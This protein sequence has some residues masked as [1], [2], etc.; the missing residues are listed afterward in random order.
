[1]YT[2]VG[3]TEEAVI[4]WLVPL[5]QVNAV[6]NVARW[7]RQQI[8]LRFERANL[9]ISIFIYGKFTLYLAFKRCRGRR[10]MKDL[11]KTDMCM[12]PTFI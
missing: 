7:R 6:M 2:Y 1:M 10:R 12:V 11:A 4:F 8:C 5:T 3:V 9:S